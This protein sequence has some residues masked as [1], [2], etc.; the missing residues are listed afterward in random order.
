MFNSIPPVYLFGGLVSFCCALAIVR[1]APSLRWL[2]FDHGRGPQRIH[3][4]Y[5][6]R[7][8]GVAIFIGACATFFSS[9][10]PLGVFM[11]GCALPVFLIGVVEDLTN[12]VGAI[13]RLLISILSAGLFV[14]CL[15]A[16][17]TDTGFLSFDSILR[18]QGLA[19]TLSICAIATHCHAVNIIDG[20]NG[21]AAASCL[22][23]LISVA[24]LAGRYGDTQLY[25]M[26]IGFLLPTAGFLFLNYPKGLLFLGDGGAYLLGAVV[27]ALVIIL[28]TRNPE[29]SSFA[30]LLIVSYP[31]YETI[32]SYL[33]RSFSQTHGSMQPDDRHLHSCV[34]KV[35]S[36]RMKGPTNMKNA[37]A[38]TF[39]LLP[40]IGISGGAVL[41]H[42]R[43]DVLMALLFGQIVAYEIVMYELKK[44]V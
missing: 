25:L 44:R 36:I 14:L 20:L 22:A 39:I 3:N 17:I 11:L 34:F 13:V 30:S 33:R 28:P 16:V 41:F 7:V 26:A 12:R 1:L 43:V 8:G 31:I 18:T 21:L 2:L 40:T 5:T 37:A 15:D 10:L 32:R 9:P 24:S 4:G 29:I 23:A 35:V 6:P 38:S 42:N 27:A 19:V